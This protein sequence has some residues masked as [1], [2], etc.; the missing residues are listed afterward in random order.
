MS[1]SFCVPRVTDWLAGAV[2]EC[3]V[4]GLFRGVKLP[5]SDQSLVILL[6]LLARAVVASL[7]RMVNVKW[8]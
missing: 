7:V 3:R 8:S 2:V 6:L 5:R 4:A 1:I